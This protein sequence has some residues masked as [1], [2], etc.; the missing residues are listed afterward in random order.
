MI[1][2]KDILYGVGIE[3]VVGATAVAINAIQ[4]DSRKISLN[5]LYVAQK[6]TQVDGH[7]FILDACNKGAL[8]IVCEVLPEQIINGITYVQ[9]SNA[10]EAL[11]HMASNFYGRPSAKL[12]LV[13]ITGTNGKTTVASL[14]YKTF[15]T[16]GEPSGLLSTIAIKVR[17]A[18]YPASHTTPDALTINYYLNKM[19]E[20]GVSHCFMEVSSHGIAQERTTALQ[21]SGAVFTNLTHDHLDYHGDFKTYRDVKKRLFDG[22]SKQ[23]FALVNEDDKNGPFMW[24]NTQALKKGYALKTLS[25]YQ[26]QILENGL[27]GLWL[28]IQNKEVWVRL[29]GKFNAYNLLAVYAVA[30]L[31]G[32]PQD[33]VLQAMSLLETVSGRFQYFI[34][35][36][37]ITVV[38]DY[39]HTPDALQNVLETL[40][41]IA[42]GNEQIITVVG[43]GGNRDKTKRPEMAKVACHLSTRCVFTSDN[44]RG[45]DPQEILQD[46]EMGIPPEHFSKTTS[47]LDRK[48]AIKAACQ[49]AMPGDIVLVAGKGHETYQEIKGVKHPFNDFEILKQTLNLLK[50]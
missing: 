18:T 24:Q 22:L 10:Q 23:A 13:G 32:K 14:L 27:E 30:N 36:T 41:H 5:D 37:K 40:Q 33:E 42:T 19:V 21:F 35:S 1:L 7:E 38:V 31:L 6:G 49:L 26:A 9:V 47:I 34:S 46:M 28:R 12:K 20:T 2:L 45:E 8:A 11:A 48:Q 16:L 17:E 25:D 29:L 15:T 44:P 39:A 50:K 3:K 4:F 43:C